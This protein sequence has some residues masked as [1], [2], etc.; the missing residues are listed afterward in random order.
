MQLSPNQTAFGFSGPLYAQVAAYLRGK[1]STSVWTSGIPLPNEAALA[2]EI[3]VSI[4]TVR[5][6]LEMLEDER[7]IDRRQGRGT[8][9]VDAAEQ[10][11][12]SRFSIL[13]Q[14]GRRLRSE[15]T[16]FAAVAAPAPSDAAAALNIEV[17]ARAIAIDLQWRA[18]HAVRVQENIIVAEAMFPGL[19]A[20]SSPTIPSLF[21]IYRRD[22]HVV[23]HRIAERIKA[24]VA[25]DSLSHALGVRPDQPLLQV[26]RVARTRTGEAVE[27]S[28]R[29]MTLGG[30]ANYDVM[31]G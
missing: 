25:D 6:A 17:G 29:T 5:K 28:R 11:D 15:V 18:G 19:S 9:V 12:L 26:T 10:A 24:V 3:G 31:L 4:G 23:V 21:Q 13:T 16:A 8:F 27:W 30:G 1:I 7:L 14:E 2:K 20:I 22:H